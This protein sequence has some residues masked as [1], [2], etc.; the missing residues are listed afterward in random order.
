MNVKGEPDLDANLGPRRELASR[1]VLLIACLAGCSLE[2]VEIGRRVHGDEPW[3]EAGT[4]DEGGDEPHPYLTCDA[5]KFEAL[6]PA[7]AVG[8]GAVTSLEGEGYSWCFMS[9]EQDADCEYAAGGSLAVCFERCLFLCDHIHPCPLGLVC[10]DPTLFRDRY[11][12]EPILEGECVLP[13]S[14]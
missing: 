2:P 8:C 6:D 10:V 3:D 7:C 11:A 13:Y 5:S 9:C 4:S 14:E 1:V 12:G